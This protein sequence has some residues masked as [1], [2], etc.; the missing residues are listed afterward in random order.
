VSHA[1]LKR[2][3][4]G[5]QRTDL[6]EETSPFE[7]FETPPLDERKGR[8]YVGI[9]SIFVRIDGRAEL[10]TVKF[11]RHPSLLDMHLYLRYLVL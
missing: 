9:F 6:I 1:E 11:N 5:E 4:T 3:I 7:S 2:R 8:V 10:P